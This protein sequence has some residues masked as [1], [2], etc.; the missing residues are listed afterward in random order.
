MSPAPRSTPA[1]TE[2]A[3]SPAGP[4]P[5]AQEVRGSESRA[6]ATA[7]RRERSLPPKAH[8]HV[9]PGEFSSHR[10][11]V[12]VWPGAGVEARM[13][14]HH[15]R[16]RRGTRTPRASPRRHHRLRRHAPSATRHSPAHPPAAKS[17]SRCSRP[18]PHLRSCD[19]E[20]NSVLPNPRV[21]SC[22]S[23]NI[24]MSASG[25]T[26]ALAHSTRV[27]LCSSSVHQ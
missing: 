11:G 18:C 16:T 6:R 2:A 20:A 19:R 12:T 8:H 17:L 15:E 21:A 9:S 13:S 3:P 4:A 14:H 5:P 24:D 7:V 10:Q 25:T 1:R 26:S 27:P 23:F 22:F